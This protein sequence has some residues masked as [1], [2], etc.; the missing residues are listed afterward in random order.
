MCAQK[1]KKS[2]YGISKRE[3]A[4]NRAEEERH[5]HGRRVLRGRQHVWGS[6]GHGNYHDGDKKG[7]AGEV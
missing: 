7:K 3:G 2:V 6:G 1:N 5:L 4:D